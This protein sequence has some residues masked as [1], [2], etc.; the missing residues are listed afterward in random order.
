MQI[1]YYFQYVMKL[2]T[3]HVCVRM[4]RT[5]CHLFIITHCESTNQYSNI[6][7]P[8]TVKAR[9]LIN[10]SFF[11]L[12]WKE[13]KHILKEETNPSNHEWQNLYRIWQNNPNCLENKNRQLYLRTPLKLPTLLD[14]LI[15]ILKLKKILQKQTQKIMT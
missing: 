11:W 1:I 5:V 7:H 8:S 14:T 2:L 12:I 4:R 9:N 15:T 10:T 3:S 13:F 6:K